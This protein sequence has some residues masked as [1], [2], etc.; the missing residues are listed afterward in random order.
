MLV[1]AAA[2]AEMGHEVKISFALDDHTGNADI[3]ILQRSNSVAMHDA[4]NQVRARYGTKFLFET[5]DN[6]KYLPPNNP[7]AAYFKEHGLRKRL[8]ASMEVCE[9]VICST[10]RLAE[11]CRKHNPNVTVC[12]NGLDRLEVEE[13]ANLGEPEPRLDGEIRIGWA[14]TN[15]HYDDFVPIIEPLSR[16]L[17]ERPNVYFEQIGWDWGPTLF[18]PDVQHKVRG[19]G[20]TFNDP[21]G[22]IATRLYYKKIAEAKWHIGIAPIVNHIFNASKSYLKLMEYGAFGI[23]AI[24]SDYG[25]YREFAKMQADEVVLLADSPKDWYRSLGLLCDDVLMR[26]RLRLANR[27]NVYGQHLMEHR[28]GSWLEA[29]TATL[30]LEQKRG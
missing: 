25:P 6:L 3:C 23:P 7:A 30:A 1:P 2:L 29:F 28:I 27:A 18:P 19:L 22:E 9:G 16:I 17:R 13:W 20:S 12:R 11:D 14:G 21:S 5:D 8:V 15:T 24:A 10:E 4:M 26:E